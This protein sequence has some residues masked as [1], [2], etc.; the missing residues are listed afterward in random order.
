[1]T[2]LLSILFFGLLISNTSFAQ[3]IEKIKGNRI[4]T[5]I[6]TDI[7]SFHTIALDED[8]EVEIIYDKNPYVQIETDENLHEVIEFQVIDSV[9]TFNKTLK[10]TSKKKLNIKVTYN[11]AFR[12]V[13]TT[14]DA[15]IVSL[16]T[17]DIENF[18]LKSSGSSKAGLTLKSNTFDF[19]GDDKSKVKLNVTSENC[20]LNLSG[21]G[22]VEALINTS[23]LSTSLYQRAIVNIEGSCD[24]SKIDLDNNSEFNGRNFTI[25]TCDIVCAISSDAY[26]EVLKDI[27]IEASGTSAVYLYQNPKLIVNKLT[28]TAKIQKKV[29]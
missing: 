11:D 3:N 16:L 4:V 29:K 7:E 8:F 24:I 10:I 22:K 9:L 13:E 25:N 28:D 21:N 20:I 19:S 1:M 23:I 5:I 6:Q 26:L 12:H 27:T 18:S 17:M 2:K 15:E 14:D